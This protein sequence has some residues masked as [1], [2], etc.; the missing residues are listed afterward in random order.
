M[1]NEVQ[2]CNWSFDEFIH[3]NKWLVRRDCEDE[4]MVL[5]RG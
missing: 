4:S 1:S 3:K 5:S 2:W